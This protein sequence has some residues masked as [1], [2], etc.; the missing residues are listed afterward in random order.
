MGLTAVARWAR[1]SRRN[2]GRPPSRFAEA[3]GSGGGA[4]GPD[5][6][7]DASSSTDEDFE[8]GSA[9]EADDDD[10]AAMLDDSAGSHLR[11]RRMAPTS[12]PARRLSSVGGT[13]LAF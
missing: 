6:D 10:D 5:S 1:P 12:L 4:P 3:D 13:L 8:P 9:A 2:A 7:E 11:S